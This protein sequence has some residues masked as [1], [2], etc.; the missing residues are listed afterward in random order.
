M[1]P[2]QGV[3]GVG[4]GGTL[5]GDANGPV[6]ANTVD[7]LQGNPLDLIGMVAGDFLQFDGTDIVP[8]AVAPSSGLGPFGEG[9]WV[10]LDRGSD[11][12]PTIGLRGDNNRPF[13][14]INSALA[15]YQAGDVIY[16]G[17][18][19][20]APTVNLDIAAAAG[21]IVII[22]IPGSTS[23][24]QNS[25]LPTVTS[26][27][28]STA[29]FQG[30]NFGNPTGFCGSFSGLGLTL[31]NCTSV[32]GEAGFQ[33][34]TGAYF[35]AKNTCVL[36]PLTCDSVVQ[37][38]IAGGSRVE[39]IT[40]VTLGQVLV[41]TGSQVGAITTG[42]GVSLVGLSAGAAAD[43]IMSNLAFA[44]FF[45]LG[46][47]TTSVTL[48][49]DTTVGA[50][51]ILFGPSL[52]S[53]VTIN[54]TGVTRQPV[55]TFNTVMGSY[56]TTGGIVD[57]SMRKGMI[58][59]EPP[60]LS[61][62]DNIYRD[63]VGAS[64]ITYV[65][66]VFGDDTL[67]QQNRQDMPFRT[68]GAALASISS[69]IVPGPQT[70]GLLTDIDEAVVVSGAIS[71][72]RFQA[73]S[74]TVYWSAPNGTSPLTTTTT[75][76]TMYAVQLEGDAAEAWVAT[77]TGAES[78]G[79]YEGGIG[80]LSSGPAATFTG[81]NV[82][83]AQQGVSGDIN[84]IDCPFVVALNV[85][86]PDGNPVFSVN[87]ATIQ[88]Q[89]FLISGILG[90]LALT[91]DFSVFIA[92]DMGV[93]GITVTA[94]AGTSSITTLGGY[95]RDTVQLDPVATYQFDGFR[96]FDDIIVS[97]AGAPTTLQMR[98]SVFGTA[99]TLGDNVNIDAEGSRYSPA[100]VSYGTG[101]S[102]TSANIFD[103]GGTPHLWVDADVGVDLN[104]RRGAEG[105]PFATI[106]GALAQAQNGD[107]IHLL[108]NVTEAVVGPLGL[109][110]IT[111]IG[112]GN[113]GASGPTVWNAGGAS[114][115]YTGTESVRFKDLFIQSGAGDCVSITGTGSEAVSFDNCTLQSSAGA[116]GTITL[117]SVEL[118]ATRIGNILSLV[119]CNT[120][121]EDA[122]WCVNGAGFAVSSPTI[123]SS[124]LG[125]NGYYGSLTA[126]GASDM[127]ILEGTAF[128][129]DFSALNETTGNSSFHGTCIGAF[130]VIPSLGS[131]Y[132]FGTFYAGI[133]INA[134]T[135]GPQFV[136][137]TGA[138]IF[139]SI[140]IGTDV[141]VDLTNANFNA[142]SISGAGE[143]YARDGRRNQ[144]VG[145][146]TSTITP[147]DRTKLIVVDNTAAARSVQLPDPTTF[148]GDVRVTCTGDADV[149]PVTFLR[150]GSE[151]INTIAADFSR[152]GYQFAVT[153]N[154]DLTDW[155]I[156]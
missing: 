42:S 101:A 85:P 103:T 65:D 116:C 9:I 138:G 57:T 50:S 142:A 125:V 155:Y 97:N 60:S 99:I 22:G 32:A 145:P 67:G 150:F 70:I 133:T 47:V 106:A 104:G 8:V 3:G 78:L 34:L 14:T 132:Q 79:M 29:Y 92:T 91:G 52:V 143:W 17:P 81:V 16:L 89:V 130:T 2:I 53:D 72:I 83:Y 48:A 7:G 148:Y 75:N 107:C 77:G 128:S 126:S 19:V 4:G 93:D 84:H 96:F 51:T 124:F 45:C 31:D 131:N 39:S 154:S 111:F 123:P 115:A 147:D 41:L 13:Q 5:V 23:I 88:S 109:S 1:I 108:T 55:S 105:A 100:S 35:S 98:N 49:V 36:G 135:I 69:P 58:E 153:I 38:Q 90:E 18:G 87:G 80:Q 127:N 119:D 136:D 113:F 6:G 118:R 102:I 21:N 54:A 61:P 139:S 43:T 63:T 24:E 26:S 120:R 95:S 94:S 112:A 56:T 30:I 37:T 74:G 15:V 27:L 28:V 156:K 114:V 129:V 151:D 121:V 73:V 46:T 20:F 122:P 62:G 144:P 40:A 86:A 140:A 12:G 137:F 71:D 146:T 66:A 141:T 64:A 152:G 117:C 59:N 76:V 33:S 11:A 110:N 44:T 25:G 82:S 134:S 149:Y 10:D 68:V